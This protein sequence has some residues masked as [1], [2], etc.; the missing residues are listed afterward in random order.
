MKKPRLSTNSASAYVSHHRTEAHHHLLEHDLALT[1]TIPKYIHRHAATVQDPC[2][3]SGRH[4]LEVSIPKSTG[5][6]LS[7]SKLYL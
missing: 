5:V 2:S 1:A 7:K 4:S 6:T 3:C